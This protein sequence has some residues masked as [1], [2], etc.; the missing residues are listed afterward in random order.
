M[1]SQ[2]RATMAV[3]A[4][5]TA[6]G[7]PAAGTLLPA[8]A[9]LLSANRAR[10]ALPEMLLTA[11]LLQDA[12]LL[13]IEHRSTDTIVIPNGVQLVRTLKAGEAAFS[14]LQRTDPND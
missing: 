2:A 1:V 3:A 7:S 8:V 9:F 11:G 12:T 10:E 5:I 14:F 6:Q 4:P 13:V